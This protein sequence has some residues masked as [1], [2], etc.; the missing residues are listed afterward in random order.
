MKEYFN[1]PQDL[2]DAV[3][4]LGRS[5]LSVSLPDLKPNGEMFFRIEGCELSFLQIQELFDE[6]RLS[7]KMI[8]KFMAQ[9]TV[10]AAHKSG[11]YVRC[12]FLRTRNFAKPH[13]KTLLPVATRIH[14][15]SKICLSFVG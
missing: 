9:Q 12:S 6:G 15:V 14:L 13:V 3:R 4:S 11:L 7:P 5:W 2:I 1:R 10:A 8:R